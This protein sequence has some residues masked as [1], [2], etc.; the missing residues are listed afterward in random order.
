MFSKI[1]NIGAHLLSTIISAGSLVAAGAGDA[2]KVTGQTI[3]RDGYGSGVIAIA[4]SATLANTKTISFAVEV[5][6]SSDGS[7]WDTAVVL[8]AATVA[9]T[10]D[11]S[12]T[13]YGVVEIDENLTGRKQYVRYNITPDLNASGTD[14]AVWGATFVLGGANRMP[15]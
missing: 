15:A 7:S 1:A 5:Q 3:N 11:S 8:Q 12:T 4:W 14:T 10:A 13:F 6:E 2:T 9:K